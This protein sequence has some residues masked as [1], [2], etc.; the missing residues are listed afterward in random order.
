[1][2][3]ELQELAQTRLEVKKE[4]RKQLHKISRRKIP[5]SLNTNEHLDNKTYLIDNLERLA[6]NHN[7]AGELRGYNSDLSTPHYQDRDEIRLLITWLLYEE[8]YPL[9]KKWDDMVDVLTGAKNV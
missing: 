5:T 7:Q 3:N 9:I 6:F 4:L 2:N 1:M 8:G